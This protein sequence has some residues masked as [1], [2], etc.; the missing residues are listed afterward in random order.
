[1]AGGEAPGARDLEQTPTW[2]VSAVCAAM[3]IVSII[4]DK[5]LHR[6]GQWFQKKHN[7]ALFDALEKVKG[8]LMILGFISL[9]LTFSQSYIAGI[10]IPL[11]YANTMLPC[12][13]K[14]QEEN[15]GSGGEP[16]RRL[17]WSQ[18]RILAAESK[19]KECKDGSVPLI[20]V[21]GLHQLH[22]FI[23]F[24][25]VFHVVYSAITMMLGKL[26]I[27]NWKDWER[28]SWN[29][30]DAMNDPARFRLTHETSFV[31][32]H[33][34][35]WTKTPILFYSLCFY[36]QFFRSVRKSDYLTMRH[37][38]ISVHLAPGS[39]FNF[40]KYIKKTLEDDFK[41]VV[42]ISPLLWASAILNLLSNVHGWKAQFC[43]SFLPLFV[44]LAVG[45][46]LQAIIAKMAIEIKERH[47]VVQGIP[48]VQV[49]DRNFWFSWPELVLYLIHFV[50]FQ[51]AFE[52]T[53]FLWA[54]YEF[55]KESCVNQDRVLIIVRVTFGVGAQVLC[56]YATL[57]LYALVTQMGSTM[58]RSIF[59]QQTSKA[60]KSWHQ[61]A[62]KKTNEVKPDQLPTRTLGG[63][64]D[65]SSV[66]S[67]SPTRSPP[68][69][70]GIGSPRFSDV[71]AE[72]ASRDQHTANITATVDVELNHLHRPGDNSS[73]F[74]QRDLLS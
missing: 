62:V 68:N 34:S 57:P 48:L 44:T 33:T 23:F 22:I 70:F 41:V 72:A 6:T 59:D 58:K 53:Y 8:E 29:E 28:E 1:M 60:L 32:G 74:V 36:R 15:V 16:H 38:F 20:S 3:I 66:H 65:A 24:L 18:R 12:Q 4:L 17:L 63:S 64:P 39:K 73:P 37:G 45:T 42:G 13:P 9:T 46:K 49:S 30:H 7:T 56:S 52:L 69:K 26:K 27:R 10:C 71:E 5:V 35:F 50:L 25:A 43:V 31:R 54:W 67:P 21:E 51:N 2:A 55:G 11:R 47:A 40:Q 61:K 19:S 14:G